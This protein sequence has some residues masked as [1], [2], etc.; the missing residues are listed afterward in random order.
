[1]VLQHRFLIALENL[2][3]K[4]SVAVLGNSRFATPNGPPCSRRLCFAEL[5]E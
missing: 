4:P 2:G 5:K 1:M 3:G